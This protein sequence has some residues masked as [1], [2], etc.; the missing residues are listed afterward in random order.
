MLVAVS[1]ST[2]PEMLPATT[3]GTTHECLKM[4]SWTWSLQAPQK[5]VQ[6]GEAES[7]AEPPAHGGLTVSGQEA[8]R[9]LGGLVQLLKWLGNFD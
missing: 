1:Q 6:E 2:E 8:R 9:L 5:T 4:M 7:T 3:D